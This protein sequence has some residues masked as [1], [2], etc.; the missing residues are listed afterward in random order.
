MIRLLQLEWI[1]LWNNGISRFL[2]VT[3]F[4]LITSVALLTTVKFDFGAVK[5]HLAEEGIFNFPF[6]WHFNSY[7]AAFLKIFFAVV[8]VA[9]IG[10][11]Y[12]YRT[13]KQNLIDGLSKAEFLLSKVYMI[14]AFVGVSTLFLFLTSLILGLI[15]SD[16]TEFSIIIMDLDYMLAYAV[17]LFGFFSFCLFLSVFIKRSAFALGLLFFW[18]F[19]E[20]ILWVWAWSKLKNDAWIQPEQLMQFF[21][22]QAMSNV[23]DEPFTR[24]SAVRNIASQI[25]QEVAQHPGVQYGELLIVL[26]WSAVFI[27]GA[28]KILQKRDL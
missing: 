1:K 26:L 23:I 12:S 19:L 8:I 6:I 27:G 3:Y 11:E 20:G 16:Y 13:L 22:M 7:L 2:I 14:L 9:L 10:N 17:K 24:L 28:Y 15:Y 4:V 5:F 21:P 18:Q 25:G